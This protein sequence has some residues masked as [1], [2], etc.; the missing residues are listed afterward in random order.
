MLNW[1]QDKGNDVALSATTSKTDATGKA[2]ITLTSTKKAVD[3][4]LVSAQYAGTA[5]VDANKLVSF[6]YEL[7]SAKVGTV[8]LD[9]DVVQ[10]V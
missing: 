5:K 4:V 3:D 9:G 8:K 7:S 1:T 6:I 10:K 2:T